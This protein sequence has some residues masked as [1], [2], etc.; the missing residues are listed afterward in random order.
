MTSNNL[1]DKKPIIPFD[2][3]MLNLYLLAS[4]KADEAQHVQPSCIT[5][6]LYAQGFAEGVQHCL[7]WLRGYAPYP[8]DV[9]DPEYAV[10]TDGYG[11]NELVPTVGEL[12]LTT[13]ATMAPYV[14][15]DF[16]VDN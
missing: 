14:D 6:D 8:F 16:E 4:D 11:K 12:G 5:I 2:M 1:D 7:D 10:I 9:D 3:Q 15:G 13:I